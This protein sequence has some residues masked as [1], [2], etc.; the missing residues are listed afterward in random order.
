M[1]GKASSGFLRKTPPIK[2][3]VAPKSKYDEPI[4]NANLDPN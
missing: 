4:V 2:N 1:L 3:P